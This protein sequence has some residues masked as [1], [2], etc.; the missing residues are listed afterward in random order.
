MLKH[1]YIYIQLSS[2]LRL[3]F[4][5]CRHYF[6]FSG[7]MCNH[8]VHREVRILSGIQMIYVPSVGVGRYNLC[9]SHAC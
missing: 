4:Y 7:M 9:D 1:I 8:V 6:M 3:W 2:V 5:M